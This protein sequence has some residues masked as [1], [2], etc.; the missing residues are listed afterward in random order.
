[1]QTLLKLSYGHRAKGLPVKLFVKEGGLSGRVKLDEDHEA[2]TDRVPDH[3]HVHN[4]GLVRANVLQK[5]GRGHVCWDG[6]DADCVACLGGK[7]CSPF[8]S[9]QVHLDTTAVSNGRR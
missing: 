4:V 9:K 7:V 1:M 2:L 5:V 8:V 6:E 3:A